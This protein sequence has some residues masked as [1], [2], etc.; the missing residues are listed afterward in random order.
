[1]R[2][3]GVLLGSQAHFDRQAAALS[4]QCANLIAQMSQV[5]SASPVEYSASL[6]QDCFLRL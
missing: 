4:W 6:K 3:C 2:G 1:L 5:F